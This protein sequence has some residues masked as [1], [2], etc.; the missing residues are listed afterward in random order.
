MREMKTRN[1]L[2]VSRILKKETDF[3]ARGVSPPLEAPFVGEGGSPAL[4]RFKAPPCPTG[5]PRGPDRAP[6]V[7]PE[8]LPPPRSAPNAGAGPP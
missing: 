3:Y 8:I 5:N 2:S 4:G 7:V 1:P 6:T